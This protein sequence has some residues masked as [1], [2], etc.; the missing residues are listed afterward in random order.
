MRWYD[1]GTLVWDFVMIQM[2]YVDWKHADPKRNANADYLYAELEKRGLPIMVMEPLRG[3]R[4]ADVPA[5][6]A[7]RMK[8]REP[9]LSPASWAFRF[10]ASHP[11]VQ[12]V[13]SGM[14]AME[15]LEENCRTFSDFHPLTDEELAFME[16]M[17][18]LMQEYP[19]VDCTDCQY[20]M[21][22]PWG[23]DIPGIFRH[24]NA[25]ITDGTFA[26]SRDQKDYSRLKRAFLVRYDRSIPTLRQADHCISCGECLSHCPQSIPIPRELQRINRY[27]EKLKQDTL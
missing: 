2:N 3:G 6:I 9:D 14:S 8:E 22:C 24:Y 20:C 16:E 12:V 25:A 21:P 19:L 26:A 11:A 13:L 5:G 7:T 17:A 18:V 4:L 10:V 1:E 23:I 27:V 15:P